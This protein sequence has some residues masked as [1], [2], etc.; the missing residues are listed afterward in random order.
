MQEAGLMERGK[1]SRGLRKG[2]GHCCL[3]EAEKRGESKRMR[4]KAR[5]LEK[6]KL[7]G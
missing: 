2:Q 4:G 1:N 6:I 7:Q 5:N 3:G